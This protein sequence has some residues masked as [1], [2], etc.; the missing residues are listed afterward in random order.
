[1]NAL[2]EFFEGLAE[3][4]RSTFAPAQMQLSRLRS[5]PGYGLKS[6][7]YHFAFERAGAPRGY[8]VAAAK[9][10]ELAYRDGSPGSIPQ[11]FREFYGGKPNKKLNPCLDP[12]IGAIDMRTVVHR[13][14]VGDLRGAFDLL[15]LRGIGHKL[16]SFFLR[17]LV[18]ILGVEEDCGTEPCNLLYCQ[19]VDTWV[20]QTAESLLSDVAA[21]WPKN[22][23]LS[24]YRLSR[25]DARTGLKVIRASVDAGVS[26]LHVNQGMWYFAS[27]I[28]ADARRLRQL[29]E[30]R[31]AALLRR[32]AE[33]LE[34]FAP[35]LVSGL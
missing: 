27:Q 28:V 1:M 17:D 8:R 3:R 35:G 30:T 9:A 7:L 16:R 31:D 15:D 20:R 26:S 4:Y 6:F 23:R 33:L 2:F 22:L 24:S 19:P 25:R 18:S 11:R 34:G 32:E 21:D 5:D 10:V 29:L 12:R 14:T 13:V